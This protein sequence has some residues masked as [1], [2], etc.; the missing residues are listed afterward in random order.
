MNAGARV[1]GMS[2]VSPVWGLRPARALRPLASK[3]PKPLIAIFSPATSDAAISPIAG[4]GSKIASIAARASRADSPVRSIN[5]SVSSALFNTSSLPLSWHKPQFFQPFT[6]DE[7]LH[8][9]VPLVGGDEEEPRS[10][11]IVFGNRAPHGLA[12]MKRNDRSPTFSRAAGIEITPGDEISIPEIVFDPEHRFH[13]AQVDPN[14]Y[15]AA[16]PW[17][18][19]KGLLLRRKIVGD[20]LVHDS[21]SHINDDFLL[22]A[23]LRRARKNIPPPP[24]PNRS[25]GISERGQSKRRRALTPHD[26][27]P[28]VL[29]GGFH[30]LEPGADNP[31]SARQVRGGG[32]F[33]WRRRQFVVDARYQL[34]SGMLV[35]A[36]AIV[37]LVLL[38]A[39]LIL[40]Q[41]AASATVATAVAPGR[42]PFGAPD[43]S[44]FALLLMGSAVFLG[45]VVVVGLLESHRTAGAAF[46]IRRVVDGIRDGQSQVRVQLRRGDH[47]QDL[48]RS[49]NQ[50]AETIDMERLRRG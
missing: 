32:P 31:I 48:A 36:V 33:G 23:G 14:R 4:S 20:S 15:A 12:I 1:A 8:V 22:H 26:S 7:N 37:L 17:K 46:A 21:A 44:S 29:G 5:L 41:R 35:G 43:R 34:R 38:N 39:S 11:R 16:L 30:L 18:D 2:S 40:P 9:V 25:P 6:Y 28:Y 10:R 42:A 45:G 24:N 49:I 3:V 27:G 19:V 50:L 13:V 47:L